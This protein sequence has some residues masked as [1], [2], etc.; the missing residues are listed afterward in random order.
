MIPRQSRYRTG[1]CRRW[2]QR[3]PPP[4]QSARSALAGGILDARLAGSSVA[5]V[6]TAPS[7]S[8]AP[9]SVTG[10]CGVTPYSSPWRTRPPNHDANRPVA[11]PAM[12]GQIPWRTTMPTTSLEAAP[13]AMRMPISLVRRLTAYATTP[14]RPTPARISARAENPATRQVGSRRSDLAA[15]PP[16][17]GP[18]S[19]VLRSRS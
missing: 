3:R 17:G 16:P 8:V 14:Y 7:R 1:V 11:M 5:A 2:L 15:R 12:A 19:S 9:T 13:S 18:C 10:S 6:V 4:A